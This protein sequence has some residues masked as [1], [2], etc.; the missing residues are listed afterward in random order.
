MYVFSASMT[1]AV[2][3]VVCYHTVQVSEIEEFSASTICDDCEH[4]G[5]VNIYSC[6]VI[7]FLCLS[8][9]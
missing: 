4:T 2:V 7:R 5:A 1:Q 9:N 3:L 8:M 6:I